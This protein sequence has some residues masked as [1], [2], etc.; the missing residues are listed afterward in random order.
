MQITDIETHLVRARETET[1]GDSQWYFCFVELRTNGGITGLGEATLPG[2]EQAVEMAVADLGREVIGRDPLNVNGLWDRLYTGFTWN[3]G[4]VSMSAL[5]AIEMA[6]WDIAGKHHG[7]RVCDLLGGPRT[8]R[9]KLYAN[10]GWDPT[11]RPEQL[12][13][14]VV[15]RHERG[16]DVVKIDPFNVAGKRV[17]PTANR[18]NSA[19]DRLAAIR[20]A[21]GRD[22]EIAVEMRGVMAPQ[23]AAE[24]VR[25]IEQF[26]PLFVEE[27]VPPENQDAMRRVRDR[28]S[29]PIAT[30]ERLLTVFDYRDLFQ[31]P[32][33]V[34]VVQPDVNN[35]GGIAQL[36]KIAAMANA[37]YVPVA[38]H[39]S[40]GPVATAA[41]AHAVSTI[42][43]FFV[44]EYYPDTPPWRQ[45]LL[46]TPET[47]IDGFYHLPD[48]D[49][50][51]VELDRDAIAEHPFDENDRT[52]VSYG[53][54]YRGLHPDE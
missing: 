14:Q 15:S 38:P 54:T 17:W 27:P 4:P 23:P 50:L 48:G 6:L 1:N 21:V 5:S 29:V 35:C 53:D 43:N 36:R 44:L 46:E 19:V 30:G 39:N 40:R 7:L 22:V 8:E 10:G 13:S 11:G 25:A 47:V 33:P 9:I 18:R 16:Y 31:H 52:T 26:D 32:T 34:D 41:A 24:C 28:L 37:E 2:L 42:P 20:D 3:S 51:G 49:G 12:A 45:D